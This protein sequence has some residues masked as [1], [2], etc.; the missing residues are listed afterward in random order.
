MAARGGSVLA[1]G[2]AVAGA[3]A[4]CAS[5]PPPAPIAAQPNLVTQRIDLPDL[6][7]VP[8]AAAPLQLPAEVF[9]DGQHAS[10]DIEFTTD[11]RGHV[12]GSK[13]AGSTRPDLDATILAQHRN[14]RYA[15]ATRV[16]R[17]AARRYRA[18]QRIELERRA[19]DVK[20]EYGAARVVELL[21]RQVVP[22]P[23]GTAGFIVPNYRTE[24]AR[25]SYPSDALREG[26]E[27]S[28]ALYVVFNADGG[29]DDVFAVN[30]FDDRW[31]F[32]ENAMRVARQ[33]KADPKPGKPIMGCV[34]IDFRIR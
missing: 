5:A 14:W 30:A 23:A 16:D 21:G 10:F 12:V 7:G 3:L 27:A 4:G 11:L 20:A 33:L 6:L 29:V 15:V 28:F 19:G 26:V 31:G 22:K 1:A 8:V 34:P 2:L 32:I 13:T 9:A 18:V 25:I 17:C 24:L